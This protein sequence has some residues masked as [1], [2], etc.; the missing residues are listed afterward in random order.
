MKQINCQVLVGFFTLVLGFGT[1]GYLLAI[2][3]PAALIRT[4][5]Y[6]ITADFVNVGGLPRG[7]KV[8]S[9]GVEIGRVG[10]VALVEDRARLQIEIT[11]AVRL[12]V[13]SRGIVKTQWFTGERYIEIAIGT[14]QER[15]PPGG[16]IDR[17]ESPR[18]LQQ[19]ISE[20][21]FGSVEVR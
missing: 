16:R 15:I 6:T 3:A 10:D 12:P 20:A 11:I 13:D 18:D 19:I 4:E 17:T 1:A 14:S 5:N 21:I 7:A 2:L 8:E 9:A